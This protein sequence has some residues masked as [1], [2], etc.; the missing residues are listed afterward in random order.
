M[1]LDEE[2]KTAVRRWKLGHHVFHLHLTVMNTHLVTL[3]KAVDEEDWVTARRLLEV[4]TRLYRAATA[5]MQYAS[6]FPRES[7]DGLLRPS[8]E[9]PWVSPGFSGKFN[10]D[11]ERMLELVKEVRG[12]LKKAAR[13]GAAPADVRDAAQ[14]LWQEQSRNRAQHKL[15]CEKFVP[16]GQSL[17]QEYFVTRP[18]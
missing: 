18:Q 6:D 12:P 4:L 2:Q 11:H 1:T 7:Y 16:G 13:T 5:C 8:M 9:P 14:R 3:R 10:T 17:L 15:I